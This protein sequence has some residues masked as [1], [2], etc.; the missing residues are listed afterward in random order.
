MS[1]HLDRFSRPPMRFLLALLAVPAVACAPPPEDD[2]SAEVR[3]RRLP[4][5]GDTLVDPRTGVRYRRNPN[6]RV[7]SAA[8]AAGVPGAAARV[9]VTRNETFREGKMS[10]QVVECTEL[11]SEVGQHFGCDVDLD[12]VV[13]GGGASVAGDEPNAGALLME[14]RPFDANLFSWVGT[15]ANHLHT[16]AHQ[17]SVF[18]IGLRLDGISAD[19]LWEQLQVRTRQVGRAAHPSTA[20]DVDSGFSVVGGGASI[21]DGVNSAN[22]P[23][24][25]FLT[26]SF[27][28][29]NGWSGAG[30]D[31][32]RECP[33]LL[34]VTVIGIRRSMP[35]TFGQL[36]VI[37]RSNSFPFN[38]GGKKT[39][40]VDL[41]GGFVPTGLGGE[42]RWGEGKGRLLVEIASVGRG[43]RVTDKDHVESDSAGSIA[44]HVLGIRCA[45][46][47]CAQ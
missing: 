22:L 36:E 31:H 44:A 18:A 27:P 4:P 5:P 6:R 46:G 1:Q 15:S 7:L 47:A 2:A 43:A 8:E 41:P 9:V 26:H 29:G 45:S 21:H 19:Q 42:A 28:Q 14:S 13:V 20:V 39:V 11:T 30:K 40:H 10:A 38:V 32:L 16:D 12:F 23:C 17:L 25:S 33:A 24:R 34:D 35:N 37:R 3:V